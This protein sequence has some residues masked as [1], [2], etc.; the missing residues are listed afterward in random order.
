M[1]RKGVQ[2]RLGEP[3]VA[4]ELSLQT[5]TIYI[6]IPIL[7]QLNMYTIFSYIKLKLTEQNNKNAN[8]IILKKTK[9]INS[10]FHPS[11]SLGNLACYL[12]LIGITPCC[13]VAMPIDGPSNSAINQIKPLKRML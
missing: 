9:G 8:Q 13:G 7:L 6:D 4:E 1:P 2:E 5:N 3:L 11:Q 12:L 10:L